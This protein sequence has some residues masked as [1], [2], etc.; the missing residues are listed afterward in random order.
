MACLA[1]ALCVAPF[2]DV[3][4]SEVVIN[5]IMYH[6]PLGLEKLQ[7]IELLNAGETEADLSGWSFSK[8]LKFLFPPETIALGG[9]SRNQDAT[10]ALARFHTDMQS[11]RNQVINR[12]KSILTELVKR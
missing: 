12:R 11:F 2:T 7:Y 8:G 4:S 3:A 9:K 10:Q 5:E 1:A 6:P